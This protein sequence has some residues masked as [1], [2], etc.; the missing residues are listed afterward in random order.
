MV[1]QTLTLG[2]SKTSATPEVRNGATRAFSFGKPKSSFWEWLGL[3]E[4]TAFLSS[5][6]LENT[7]IMLV[8]EVSQVCK[9]GDEAGL[10]SDSSSSERLTSKDPKSLI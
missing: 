4:G 9:A 6:L 10:K 1:T 5:M 3:S 8:R 7:K 2:V